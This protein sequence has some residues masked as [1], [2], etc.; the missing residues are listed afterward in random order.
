M[1]TFDIINLIM[2]YFIQY[3]TR[4]I[5]REGIYECLPRRMIPHRL[6]LLYGGMIIVCLF[7]H[8][9][10]LILR[11]TRLWSPN[12]VESRTCSDFPPQVI[13]LPGIIRRNAM[14]KEEEEEDCGRELFHSSSVILYFTWSKASVSLQVSAAISA[15]AEEASAVDF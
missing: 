12:V 9:M 4:P 15:A 1:V 6:Y 13:R 11:V 5:I 2:E 8:G 7:C 3:S 14:L 10:L